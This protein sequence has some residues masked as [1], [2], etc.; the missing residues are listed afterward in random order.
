MSQRVAPG[1]GA[2][3][4]VAAQNATGY[5][6]QEDNG[7]GFRDLNEGGVYAVCGVDT[8]ALS[9]QP[10]TAATSDNKYRVI[11]SGQTAPEATSSEASLTVFKQPNIASISPNHGLPSGGTTVTI[12]GSD[13]TTLSIV[14][15]QRTG[16]RHL[17][18]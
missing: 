4:S 1:A 6:W 18:Q 9:V 14:S 13:F 10:V 8:A 12:T 15:W 3:F 16:V 11:V 5:R 2:T 17:C 7:T